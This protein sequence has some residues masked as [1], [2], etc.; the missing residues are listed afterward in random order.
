L[1]EPGN[2]QMRNR[3]NR[4]I[5]VL[6]SLVAA[7]AILQVLGNDLVWDDRFLIT[8]FKGL[9]DPSRLWDILTSPFW[10]N[11]T[12]VASKLTDFWRPLTTLLLWIVGF[13]FGNWAP[14]YHGISVISLLVAVLSLIA[15][16]KR[17]IPDNKSVAPWLG[18]VFLVHPLSAEVLCMV[19]NTA[20]H[21]AFAFLTLQVVTLYDVFTRPH[22]WYRYPMAALWGLLACLSKE[23]GILTAAT[24]VAVWL[25][26]RSTKPDHPLK[27]LVRPA[28]WLVSLTPAAVYMVMRY[29]VITTA[30]REQTLQQSAHFTWKVVFLGVGQAMDRIIVP[31]PRGAHTFVGDG[32]LTPWI[33]SGL[34]WA[35]IIALTAW[36]VVKRRF[37]GSAWTGCVFFLLLAMP[38]LLAV[39]IS[40]GSLRFP[41][42]Y[43]HLPLAG[44]LIA[45]SPF[46]VR[47]WSRGL[48]LIAPIFVCLLA[49][50][51][52]IRISEWNDQVAFFA[53]ETDHRPDSLFNLINLSQVLVESHAFTD[54]EEVL[55]RIESHP[56]SGFDKI[57]ATV[58]DTRAKIVMIRDGDVN[59]A[60]RHVEAALRYRPDNLTYV[61]DLCTLRAGAGYPDQAITILRKALD[62][63]WFHDSRRKVIELHLIKYQRALDAR[64]KQ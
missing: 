2:I 10:D 9:G 48:R 26:V 59:T 50:L 12:Y 3:T 64:N 29:L 38:S 60:T 20:D 25:L 22:K 31:I 30:G 32:D 4:L 52:W 8:H 40:E 35:G 49:L 14:A 56:D 7:T 62:S 37:P 39:D 43:F 36:V 27:I 13:F 19:V 24:P 18:L 11:S 45:I 28:Q 16:I 53:A 17:L 57:K 51:S 1:S 58:Y 42:R 21:L 54:A 33:V 15:L 63:P 41:T 61:L 23:I 44:L 6:T 46:A 5:F 47:N 34:C 55:A